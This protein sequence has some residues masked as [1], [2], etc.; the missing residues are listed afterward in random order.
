ME[1]YAQDIAQEIRESILVKQQT[2]RLSPIIA[3]AADSIVKSYKK[4][5]KLVVFGNGGSAADAQHIVGELVN[6][7]HMDRDMLNALALNVNTSVIT[8]IGNDSSYDNIFSRQIEFLVDER[9]VVMGIS[10]SGNSENVIRGLKKAKERGALT[11]GLTGKTGGRMKGL[12]D[13][14][15][16]IPSDK[17]TRIQEAHIT[18]GHI[19]CGLVERELFQ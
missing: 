3:K 10:T 9:D 11:I 4:G 6:K 19:I 14:I 13:I 15:V 16:N 2:L 5:G 1:G 7:L 18:I 12:P 8:A 17:V